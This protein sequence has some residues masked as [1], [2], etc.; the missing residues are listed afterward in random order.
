VNH[1]DGTHD[2]SAMCIRLESVTI[3]CDMHT[4]QNQ[5]PLYFSFW[6]SLYL[7]IISLSGRSSQLK[8]NAHLPSSVQVLEGFDLV[9]DLQYLP[10]DFFSRPKDRLKVA[11]CGVLA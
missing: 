7:F 6:C 10:V 4:L 9:K 5:F 8:S 2:P 3:L 1:F 11:D